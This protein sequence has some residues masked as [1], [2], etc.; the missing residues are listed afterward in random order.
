M[1]LSRD[2]T[3]AGQNNSPP[4]RTQKIA[5]KSGTIEKNGCGSRKKIQR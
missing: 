5:G 4:G 2:K 3:I 1:K